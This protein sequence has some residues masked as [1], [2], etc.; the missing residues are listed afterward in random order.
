MPDAQADR[1]LK[2][3]CLRTFLIAAA[4][5]ALLAAFVL[6]PRIDLVVSGWFYTPG[7]GFTLNDATPFNILRLV[8]YAGARLLGLAL[9]VLV[10]TAA[11]RHQPAFDLDAKAYLFLFLGLLLGPALIAN[12]IFKDHWGR[13]R[14]REIV[15]F[16]GDLHFSPALMPSDE[17]HHNCS[18]VSGDGAFGFYLPA[19]AYVV[20]RS[21]ARRWFWG[22]MAAGGLFGFGRLAVGAHFLSDVLFAALFMQLATALLHMGMYGW[23]ETRAHWRDW[24]FFPENRDR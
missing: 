16:G 5:G 2:A 10:L 15:E 7:Q 20:P 23:Q 21:R 8:A 19:F 11:V 22:G 1:K 6:W 12:G 3:P 4:A 24:L 17:C 14:P 9:L 18:F 13:A